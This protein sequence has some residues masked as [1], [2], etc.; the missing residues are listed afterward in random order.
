M[1]RTI[2]ELREA[3]GESRADLAEALGVPLQQVMEWEL[4]QA[5][6]TISRLR[7]LTEHFGVCDDQIELEPGRPPS[8]AD[9]L[10][11]LH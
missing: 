11:D 2:W 4:D 8:F 3:R 6:P 10:A 5:T 7:A 1:K 9:R